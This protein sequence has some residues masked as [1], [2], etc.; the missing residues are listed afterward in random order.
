VY[1]VQEAI[2]SPPPSVLGELFGKDRAVLNLE[3]VMIEIKKTGS[4]IVG[5]EAGQKIYDKY[6]YPNPVVKWEVR[7]MTVE[8]IPMVRAPELD[9]MEC[10]VHSVP[11]ELAEYD[12]G[13]WEADIV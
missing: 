10:R 8:G 3:G 1:W 4:V 5:I 9:S 13:M 12:F 7:L 11:S 6:C 2:V